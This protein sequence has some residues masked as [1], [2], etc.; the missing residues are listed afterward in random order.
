MTTVALGWI[1]S[2]GI[3]ILGVL[4]IPRLATPER[5]LF[6][7]GVLFAAVLV[8]SLLLQS[9]QPVILATGLMLQGLARGSMMTVAIMLLM[10]T[11][12]VP[13]ER[14]GLAG[15]MFFTSA[16]IGGVLFP[17]IHPGV[18]C[19]QVAGGRESAGLFIDKG[20]QIADL[21][22]IGGHGCRKTRHH[23]PVGHPAHDI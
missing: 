17:H 8:A 14:L 19:P 1:A 15:G 13:E 3:G 16:E 23:L 10:E 22:R 18:A 20:P 6:V 4:V 2:G 9:Q 12:G 11:P 7:M 21:T 5:R